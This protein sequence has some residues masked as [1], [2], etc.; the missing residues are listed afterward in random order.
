MLYLKISD[1]DIFSID[2]IL[3][4]LF[5]F[6]VQIVIK[7]YE[8]LKKSVFFYFF[9]L[10]IL[11]FVAFY[12]SS[13][14]WTMIFTLNGISEIGAHVKSNLRYSIF[15]KRLILSRAVTYRIFFLRKDLFSFIC[16]RHVLS[17]PLTQ[18]PWYWTG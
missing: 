10:Y 12:D 14:Y 7:K 4:F 16:A 18:V 3:F 17:Y 2:V 5:F 13:L 15:F 1:K 9:F 11:F 8:K 6:C